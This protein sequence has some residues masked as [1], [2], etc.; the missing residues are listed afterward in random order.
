MDFETYARSKQFDY[1]ALAETMESILRAAIAAHP[2]AFRLQQVQRRAKNP[3]SLKK[4]LEDRNLLSTTTLEADIKDLAGCRLIFYTNSDVSRFLQSGIIQ[5]NF[6]VDWERTKI[7]HPVPGK[8]DPD[9]FFI[10]NNYVVRLKVDRTALPEYARFSDIWCEVQVQTTLNHA[11]SEMEHDILYKK[12]VVEG[13]GGK[14]FEA[15]RQRL[16]TIMKTHLLPAGYEFQKVLDDFERLMSGKAILDRGSL[17]AL[18]KYEDNNARHEMLERFRDYVLPNYDDPQSVYP[19][20]KEQIVAAVKEA[21]KAKPRPI[22]TP[23]GSYPGITV[24]RVV[25]VA[26]D[27]F[28]QLRYVNIETTF[29]AVC[30][31]FPGAQSD[32]ERKQLLQVAE[33]LAQHNMDAWKQVGPFV[34]TVLVQSIRKLAQSNVDPL[35]PVLLEVLGEVLGTEIRG[36][37]STYNTVTLH[38]GSVV[39]SDALTRMRSEALDILMQLYRSASSTDQKRQTEITIFA[40]TNTPSNYSKELLVRVL[41]DS[42]TVANFCREIAATDAYEIIQTIEDKLLWLHRRCQGIVNDPKSDAATVAAANRLDLSIFAF[43]N[44]V[45]ANTR[46]TIYKTLVGYE[47]VFPPAWD[48]GDF[49]YRQKETYRNERIDELVAE[50]NAENADEWFGIIQR[51]AQTESDNL[52]TFPSFGLFLQK[53][54]AAKPQIVLGFIGKLDERLKGFLGLMLSGLAQSDSRIEMEAKIAQWLAEEKHLLQ[55]AHYFRFAPTLES[56][57]LQQVL[58]LGIRKKDDDIVA[59]VLATVFFRYKDGTQDLI[60]AIVMPAIEY[61]TNRRD[62]RWVNLAWY[63]PKEESPLRDLTAAQVDSVLKSLLNLAR[64]DTHAEHV[65]ELLAA[66]YPE[67]VFDFFGDRLT[68][69]A[70]RDEEGYYEAV[71]HQLYELQKSF[72]NIADHAVGTVRRLFAIDDPLFQFTGGRLLSSSFPDFSDAFKEKISSYIQPDNR[73]DIEF[74]VRVLSSYTG[75]PFLYETCRD[76][77]R[78]L[79][80]DDQLLGNVQIILQTT[81]LVSGEFGF[82]EAYKQKRE[83]VATWLSDGDSKVRS[84]A[85]QYVGSLDRQ[86]AAEQRRSEEDIEMRK[87]MYG[88]RSGDNQQ[89]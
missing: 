74:V 9:N 86:I 72:A 44:V 15:I 64:V 29:D 48:D 23:M 1:A 69:S 63:L 43:R 53:L 76:I 13:F 4:K 41:N 70:A 55:I 36:T 61:F 34:Q 45:D 84:F 58:A 56:E 71:P 25:E 30:E 89:S 12:P 2:G 8:T 24:E 60:E 78:A 33:R 21:R 32:Q 27:I 22:E 28:V 80:I 87:R 40:A 54:S 81:G 49:D 18:A 46:F 39:A 82:V 67:K 7:H 42:V 3:A 57:V 31:L 37:S 65:L 14:L 85:Q 77:V 79:P 20:V 6:D 52:A 5:D 17:K 88:D 26:A 75:Q 38:S 19:E 35:R 68:F 50:V 51:S 73:D 10:S 59:Q 83:D 47:S 66:T 11:W 62:A 16:Q